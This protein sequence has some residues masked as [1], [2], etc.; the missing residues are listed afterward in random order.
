MAKHSLHSTQHCGETLDTPSYPYR[1]SSIS[2]FGGIQNLIRLAELC[3][4]SSNEQSYAI[5]IQNNVAHHSAR[6]RFL[7]MDFNSCV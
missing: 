7:K 1:F 6:S 3:V 5:Y 2:Y 4:K